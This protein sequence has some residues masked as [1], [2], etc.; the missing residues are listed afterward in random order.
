MRVMQALSLVS[1]LWLSGCSNNPYPE[2]DEEKKVLYTSF[3]EPPKTLDPA[4]A[5]STAD[6]AITGKVYDTLL[7]YHYLKR[8][9]ELIGGL[10]E[11]VPEDVALPDGGV[12]YRFVL[13]PDLW[14]QEDPCFS[15]SGAKKRSIHAD[16]F[17]FAL[18][19]LADPGVGSPVVDPFSA[20]RGFAAF[21]QRLK[22][23]RAKDAA[24]KKKPLVEQ[25][26]EIGG[27][28]GAQSAGE[29]ELIVRI[30][31]PYPQILYWFAMNFSSPIPWEAIEYYDGE[32]GRPTFSEHPV[33]SG[34][35]VLSQYDK[36]A[37]MVLRKNPDWYGVRHPEWRAPG[38]TFP[39]T[40]GVSDL[41]TAERAHLE[42]SRGL[43]LPLLD[44]IEYRREEER[45]PAFSKFMQGYYDLSAVVRESF[46]QIVH[47]GG[48]S[49][50]M[51][52]RGM[53]LEK[54]VSPAVYYMGFN[55]D[56]PVVGLPGGE[57]ARLLRQAMSLVIDSTEYSRLFMNGR[58]IPAHSPIPPGIFGYEED[59]KNA[60]RQVDLERAQK[61]LVRA[62]YPSG[63]DP[64]TGRPLALTFDV[65][66]TSPEG[67]LRFL[68]WTNQWRR[69]GIHVELSATNYNK[70]QE[71]VRDGA[72]Q[73][74]QWGWIAD[75]PDPENFYFLLTTAMA[76]SVSGGPNTANFKNDEYDRLFERMKSLDNGPERLALIREM[77]AILERERPWIELFYPEDYALLHGWLK[78]V[79]PAGLSIPTTKYYDIDAELRARAR[80][81][82]NEPILWPLGALFLLLAL[83][84][85]PGVF[86]FLKE[87][88]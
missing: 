87:R 16:D 13:R 54:S 19:R 21:G 86:T 14:F 72:Y 79:R 58:G 27:F 20:L 22:E 63:I 67:R 24:F 55:L 68:F 11:S 17:V 2:A 4:L 45:I 31:Q 76:R 42:A 6:H 75:Y 49:K 71:K 33:A 3:S 82:W 15:L 57:R 65:P 7:E 66:D 38:A 83:V 50:E 12:E 51:Q 84:L 1:C 39:S 70:F 28:E 5:Y 10:A 48:L 60:F 41:S 81:E 47:E 78:N 88:Q 64:K 25:Y 80:K 9:Y 46:N 18:S 52:E 59:Y 32:E 29:R 53:Q 43:A 74:F 23:R 30:D 73:I 56:D 36:R 44:R 62:G 69:L 40:E 61:L 8:P 35:F 26:R 85:V 77:R 34:P 37:R